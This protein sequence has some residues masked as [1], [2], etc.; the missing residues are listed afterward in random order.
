MLLAQSAQANL[1]VNGDFSNGLAGWT[2][3]NAP[4]GTV[5]VD[6]AGCPNPGNPEPCAHHSTGGGSGGLY[7][8][9]AVPVGQTLF[10]DADWTGDIGGAGWAELIVAEA[11]ADPVAFM[12]GPAGPHVRA[13][14]DSW[15]ENPPT[16]WDWESVTLSPFSG[17]GSFTHTSA[18]GLIIVG[19]KLG[20]GG[21]N[22]WMCI[23]NIDVNIPEPGTMV[24]L[25][26][27][28]VGLVAFARRKIR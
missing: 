8:I 23:D 2:Y 14:K 5:N 16:S 15:G 3:W 25:G 18:S 13:K 1:V 4:W 11:P 12:D 20:S 10:I 24:L 28:L 27:G 19:T 9:V 17:G 6:D 21:G 22:G 26:S 7:Q